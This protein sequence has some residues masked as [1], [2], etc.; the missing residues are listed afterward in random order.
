MGCVALVIWLFT[1]PY[2]VLREQL[3]N[4]RLQEITRSETDGATLQTIDPETAQRSIQVDTASL[5]LAGTP[6][7]SRISLVVAGA[8]LVRPE[9]VSP[10]P[11]RTID[12]SGRVWPVISFRKLDAETIRAR[13]RD[14]HDLIVHGR[15]FRVTLFDIWPSSRGPNAYSFLVKE[16]PAR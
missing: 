12:R 9:E 16:L 13:G 2:T 8:E 4:E 1:V 5:T 3:T 14:S 6:T 10:E 7:A 11:G 15:R